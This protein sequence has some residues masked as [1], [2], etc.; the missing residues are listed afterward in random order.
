MSHNSA[1][2]R[3]HIIILIQNH[4]LKVEIVTFLVISF[5]KGGVGDNEGSNDE[6]GNY[7][8]HGKP[9]AEAQRGTLRP[10]TMNTINAEFESFD[11]TETSSALRYVCTT[12][13]VYLGIL[14]ICNYQSG[15][16]IV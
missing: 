9:I 12:N 14:H 8:E 13:N 6:D 3:T 1:L 7:D 5:F 11:Y 4:L 16:F 10:G 15:N 2:L